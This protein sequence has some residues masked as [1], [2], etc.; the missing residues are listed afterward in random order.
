MTWLDQLADTAREHLNGMLPT[1]NPLESAKGF[2]SEAVAQRIR[3]E[4]CAKA[5]GLLAQAHRSVAITIIWQNALL[6]LSLLPVYVLHSELPFYL[7]YAIVAGY[8]IYTVVKFWPLVRQLLKTRSITETLS[9]EVLVA[10]NSE[11]VHRQFYERAAIEWLGA[12]LKKVAH[13]VARKLKPDVLTAAGNMGFTLLLT[14][15]TFRLFIIP[16]LE[17]QAMQ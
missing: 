2:M 1:T 10:I 12:D 4:A 16:L 7:A 3:D 9:A 15:V 8:S 14:F 6:L 11:L 17:Q 13:D 5:Y